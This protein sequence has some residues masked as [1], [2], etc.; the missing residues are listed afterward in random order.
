VFR[1]PVALLSAA[2][3]KARCGEC[4]HVFNVFDRLYDDLAE[5]RDA[6][7]D[8]RR[9]LVEA[10]YNAEISAVSSSAGT[11]EEYEVAEETAPV[12]EPAA[13]Q[14]QPLR[15]SDLGKLFGI[16]ALTAFLGVQWIWF[17]RTAL[18][19]EPA[20]R[21]RI[22][23]LCAFLD[24]RLPLRADLSQLV[25]V[26][27]DV[28]R[29]PVVSSALVIDAVFENHSAFT[30]RY[31]VFEVSFIDH[32]GAPVAMRRFLPAEYLGTGVDIA[33]GMAP[34]A[35]VNVALD[36][37]DPGKAADSFQFDFL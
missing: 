26:S 22:E 5:L 24:C 25:V 18:A 29:H 30:Q 32:S 9:R 35:R 36:V 20:W 2:E 1:V 33:A 7:A 14:R 27:R 4:R 13:W 19:A 17:N 16:L 11:A 28:H 21:P 10:K 6:T 3:G 12:L 15:G 34:G 8:Q 23:K 31:P 37:L